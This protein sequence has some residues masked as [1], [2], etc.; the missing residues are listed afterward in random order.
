M[1]L[2]ITNFNSTQRVKSIEYI[3]INR[4]FIY[5]TQYMTYFVTLFTR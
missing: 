2:Y 5:V 1:T 3:F 4:N